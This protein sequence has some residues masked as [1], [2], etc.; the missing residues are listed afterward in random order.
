MPEAEQPAEDQPAEGSREQIGL[1]WADF[2]KRTVQVEF[3]ESF[4]RWSLDEQ[5]SIASALLEASLNEHVEAQDARV[6]ALTV[7][8]QP[9]PAAI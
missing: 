9:A 8:G 5:A 7:S 1:I 6:D 4:Y 2:D 3:S